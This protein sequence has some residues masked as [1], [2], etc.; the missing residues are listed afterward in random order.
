MSHTIKIA[1]TS[2]STVIK[3]VLYYS[4]EEVDE[5]DRMTRETKLFQRNKRNFDNVLKDLKRTAHIN[6]SNSR[7]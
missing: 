5:L 1:K 3:N 6:L 7:A 4:K 2:T